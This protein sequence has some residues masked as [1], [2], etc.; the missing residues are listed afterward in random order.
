MEFAVFGA[1]GKF[2]DAG[3][4]RWLALLNKSYGQCGKS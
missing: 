4:A 1:F 2:L 3:F